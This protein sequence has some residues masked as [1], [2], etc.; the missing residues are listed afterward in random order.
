LNERRA[1]TGSH[2]REECGSPTLS[3]ITATYNSMR[4]IE[5][6]RESVLGSEVRDIEWIVV[7]DGSKDGTREYLE[8]IDE[9]RSVLHLET[10]NRGIREAYAT[11]VSLARGRYVLILDHDDTV[12]SGSLLARLEALEAKPDC[13][14]AFGVTAYMDESGHVYGQSRFPFAR[15]S[16]VLSRRRVMLG[17][18]LPPTYPLKQGG[19]VLRTAFVKA[20]PDTYDIELFLRAAADGG[21]AFVAEPCLNYR[22]FRGQ[23]SSSRRSRIAKFFQ[24]YWAGFA[25]R[26]LPWYLGP[27][28]ALYRTGI[29][30]LK[31]VWCLF[32]ARRT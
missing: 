15:R 32:S 4:Y 12:P 1:D 23:L 22:T 9:P 19:A 6:T 25:L 2:R 18:F 11:G 13:Q 5:A 3:I 31:V 14:V 17:V 10:I 8:G 27:F 20:N 28:V 26:F 21:A 30:L 29:E 7:D 24:L 16:G